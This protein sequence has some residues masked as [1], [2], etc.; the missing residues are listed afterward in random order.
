MRY[1]VLLSRN[2]K[3]KFTLVVIK[4]NNQKT[5]GNMKGASH[6][7]LIHTNINI[8]ILKQRQMEGIFA[9]NYKS[10]NYRML[11]NCMSN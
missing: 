8:F 5:L 10:L 2:K 3:T 9:L 7:L 4:R 6:P 11:I 1:F